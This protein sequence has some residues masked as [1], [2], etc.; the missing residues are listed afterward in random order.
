MPQ[1]CDVAA[2]DQHRDDHPSKRRVAAGVDDA[3][4][5][6]VDETTVVR[7]RTGSLAEVLLERSQRAGEADRHDRRCPQDRRHMQPDQPRPLD[8]EQAADCDE[9]DEAQ[10]DEH[11]QIGEQP[12]QHELCASSNAADR[13]SRALVAR[14]TVAAARWRS[15]GSHAHSSRGRA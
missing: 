1:Q 13:D 11:H 4:E 6:V 7:G 8:G 14:A 3:I 10:V 5:V 12:V 15:A 9:R 2:E